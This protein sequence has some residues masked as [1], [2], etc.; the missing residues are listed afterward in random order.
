MK[1][2]KKNQFLHFLPI[3]AVYPTYSSTHQELLPRH[4]NSLS[5]ETWWSIY[6][7][8]VQLEEKENTVN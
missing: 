6:E 3:S 7:V 2:R 8:K 4:E 5:S 1:M